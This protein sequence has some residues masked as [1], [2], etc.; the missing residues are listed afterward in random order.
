MLELSWKRESLT[1]AYPLKSAVMDLTTRDVVFIKIFDGATAGFGEVAPLPQWGTESLLE[2]ICLL[3]VLAR[4]ITDFESPNKVTEISRISDKL[5]SIF[6]FLPSL[7]FAFESA[8]L[9]LICKSKKMTLE[10]LIGINQAAKINTAALIPDL[11]LFQKKELI[12]DYVNNGYKTTKIKSGNNLD[13]LNELLNWSHENG[14]NLTFRIDFNGS[15]KS[16]DIEQ[17]EHI[18]NN[19]SVQ[20]IEQPERRKLSSQNFEKIYPFPAAIDEEIQSIKDLEVALKKWDGFVI[21]KPSTFRSP[22]KIVNLLRQSKKKKVIISSSMDSPLNGRI[23]YTIASLFPDETHGLGTY[24][25][26]NESH[27]SSLKVFP[28]YLTTSS[29]PGIGFDSEITEFDSLS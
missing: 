15:L 14:F 16:E 17:L 20:Y 25:L 19:N 10:Q 28:N 5:A 1:F 27:N 12:R 9:D 4:S 13:Q 11:P 6:S 26:L 2:A 21:V 3:P 18:V 23:N 22:I 24:S 29:S 8:L 7:Q